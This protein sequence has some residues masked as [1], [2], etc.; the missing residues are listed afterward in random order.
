[1]DSV[2]LPPQQR[3]AAPG[4]RQLPFGLQRP[5]SVLS[6]AAKLRTGVNSCF[7]VLHGYS[8]GN[9]VEFIIAHFQAGLYIF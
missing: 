1:M 9:D 8:R 7:F 6:F 4:C 5:V 2:T 3:C